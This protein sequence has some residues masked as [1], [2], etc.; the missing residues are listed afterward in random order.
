VQQNYLTVSSSGGLNASPWRTI[1]CFR[2]PINIGI[3]VYSSGGGYWFEVT[4]E[5]PTGIIARP[6][7]V[8]TF[9][10][11]ATSSNPVPTGVFLSSQAAGGG[12]PAGS[13]NNMGWIQQPI[14]AIRLVSNSSAAG[15]TV[16]AVILQA[17][18][19]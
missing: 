13:S 10:S 9:V 11:S 5:D 4:L 15:G 19:R 17:G 16:S 12:I 3:A 8:A 2:D 18:P 7:S 14:A 1:D 6:S